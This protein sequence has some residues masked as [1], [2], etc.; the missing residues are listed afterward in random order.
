MADEQINFVDSHHYFIE[1]FRESI[2]LVMAIHV[3]EIGLQILKGFHN[4]F[5]EIIN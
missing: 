1:Y 3:V 4:G 5:L 2:S